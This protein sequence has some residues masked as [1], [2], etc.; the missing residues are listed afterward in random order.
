MRK[1]NYMNHG[2]YGATV[3]GVE[4]K[5]YIPLVLDFDNKYYVYITYTDKQ[6]EKQG[7]KEYI[8]SQVY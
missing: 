7:E 1:N 8:N 4:I 5:A 2:G 6:L 3:G